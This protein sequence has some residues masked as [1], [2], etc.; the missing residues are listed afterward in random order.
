MAFVALYDGDIL[1]LL[2]WLPTDFTRETGGFPHASAIEFSAVALALRKIPFLFVFATEGLGTWMSRTSFAVSCTSLVFGVANKVFAVYAARRFGVGVVIAKQTHFL[3]SALNAGEE[4][5]SADQRQLGGVATLNASAAIEEETFGEHPMSTPLIEGADVLPFQGL[6]RRRGHG[7]WLIVALLGGA[8]LSVVVATHSMPKPKVLEATT[9]VLLYAMGA[10]VAIASVGFCSLRVRRAC[11]ESKSTRVVRLSDLARRDE[12]AEQRD[13]EIKQRDDSITRRDDRL[14][15]IH[16]QLERTGV[17]VDDFAPLEEAKA[18][19]RSAL[20]RLERGDDPRAEADCERWDRVLQAHP[21]YRAELEQEAR[22][23]DESQ[24]A[25]NEAALHEM[26]AFVPVDV[27]VRTVDALVAADVPRAL[28]SRLREKRALWLV[29]MHGDDIARL[30]A[31]DLQHTYVTLGLDLTEL[32]A[33]FAAAPVEF[34]NDPTGQKNAWRADL[35]AKLRAMTARELRPNELRSA[36]YRGAKPLFNPALVPSRRESVKSTA[37]EPVARPG[38]A[39]SGP[40][41]QE[42][43]A[44]LADAQAKTPVARGADAEAGAVTGAGP[45]GGAAD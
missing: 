6:P 4:D 31:A 5:R 17:R 7:A 21:Q 28:A 19:Y 23:W 43:A 30:H 10:V 15:F 22:A 20:A 8:G 34:P 42:R 24:R 38:A 29:R 16:N 36:A 45:P 27:H 12:E 9:R 3:R 39:P 18:R 1:A 25:P 40:S 13:Q 2:P 33:V 11:A 44:V 35:R 32:R 37:F 26:R 41:V 14:D